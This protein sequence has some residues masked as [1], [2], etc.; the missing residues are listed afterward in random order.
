LLDGNGNDMGSASKPI[1]LESSDDSSTDVEKEFGGSDGKDDLVNDDD[2]NIFSE[3]E[4]IREPESS[5]TY[6]CQLPPKLLSHQPSDDESATD[7]S[8]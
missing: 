7:L 6:G 1:L 3:G 5:L 8:E 2:E 4:L